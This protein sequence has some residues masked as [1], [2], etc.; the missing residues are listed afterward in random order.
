MLQLL[1][2]T[3][4]VPY[5]SV[6]D[7]GASTTATDNTKAFSDAMSAAQ[8]S[9]VTSVVYAPPGRWRF[10][11][12]FV[13]PRGVTLQGSYS[14]VPSH[15]EYGAS[16]HGLTDGTVLEPTQGRGSTVGAPF[17]TLREN[18]AIRG[19]VIYH[20]EQERTAWPVPYPWTIQL[21][22]NNAAVTDVEL[23][24]PYLGINATLAGRHYIARVQGQPLL[25][26][27]YVDQTYD[28]GRIEDVHFNPWYS[29][30]H[31]FVEFQLVHGR[32]F[33]F[34]R[35]DWEYVL[36]TF[37]S[38]KRLQPSSHAPG[39]CEGS[40]RASRLVQ[41]FGYA[42]GYHFIQ[43]STGSMNG[44]FVGLGAD[45]AVNASVLVDATQPAGLLITNGE[46]TAFHT[47]QWINSTVESTHVVVS[48]GPCVGG[49]PVTFASSSFWGPASQVALLRGTGT[50]SFNNC[51]FVAW[52]E[53]AKDGR[54]AI[55]AYAGNLILRGN[56][57]EQDKVQVELGSGVAKAS[58][59]GNVVKGK[60]RVKV[61]STKTR[62]KAGLNV[63]DADDAA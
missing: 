61:A 18:A 27:L 38:K 5:I 63:D 43:T 12:S 54:A 57:F 26:G 33:V 22:G 17:V 48:K 32:A 46:F 47:P 60:Y 62:V 40:V 35:S 11:G 16:D 52:D 55:R 8:H 56:T 30:K 7:H 1:A 58:I 24:N 51:N 45:L 19:L 42:V 29:T 50:T 37:V 23:L 20:V 41:A 31:P 4:A 25:I 13:L 34:G 14:S 49:C 9:N 2:A 28:I 21:S 10:A 53:Q 3:F 44:N 59:V 6:V 36:N 39:C 15:D